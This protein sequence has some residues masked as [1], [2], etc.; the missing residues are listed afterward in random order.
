[1][2][3]FE[4]TPEVLATLAKASTGPGA[5]IAR[6]TLRNCSIAEAAVDRDVVTGMRHS[7]E[8]DLVAYDVVRV[9]FFF[10]FFFVNRFTFAVFVCV[11]SLLLMLA[12]SH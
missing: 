9:F 1:M 7:A 6:N 11:H 12:V 3:T 5:S 10:F 4:L 2:S 8:V